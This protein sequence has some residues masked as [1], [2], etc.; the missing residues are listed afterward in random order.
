MDFIKKDNLVINKT[1]LK[2]MEKLGFNSFEDIFNFKGGDPVKVKKNRSVFRIESDEKVF[3]LKRNFITKKEKLKNLLNFYKDNEDGKN[4]WDMI[5]RLQ[6]ENIPVMKPVLFGDIR[7][8]GVEA[9]SVLITEEL[10]DTLKLT[11]YFE[12]IKNDKDFIFKKRKILADI[13]RLA[14][15]FHNKGFHHQ[16]F[17]L[18]HFHLRV[19]DGKLYLVDLQR[20]HKKDDLKERWLV[21]DLSQFVFSCLMHDQ[22]TRTDI[23]RF[24]LNYFDTQS[25]KL[26]DEIFIDKIFEKVEKIM[27]HD[28]KLRKRNV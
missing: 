6:V 25:V 21:K 12:N 8:N 17:Y 15:T 23:V 18:V 22:V 19:S 27:K 16:D 2:E 14:K 9:E 3:Y 28:A 7:R 26:I 20:V 11:D 1:F 10:Y 4:E 5:V 13:G 24:A